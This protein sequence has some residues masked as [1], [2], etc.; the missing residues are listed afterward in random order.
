MNPGI[1]INGCGMIE[2]Q[3]EVAVA[4]LHAGTLSRIIKFGRLPCLSLVLAQILHHKGSHTL[5]REQ[6]LARGVNGE[7]PQ[8]AGY[9][10]PAELLGHGSGCSA[11]TEAIK[12]Q[13]AFVG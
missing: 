1:A 11:A 7:A 2:L 12:H 8:V 10:A 9:P 3:D 5:D 4:H 13:V 6:T